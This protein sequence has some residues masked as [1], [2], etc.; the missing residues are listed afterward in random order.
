MLQGTQQ[1]T[2]SFFGVRQELMKWS[3]CDNIAPQCTIVGWSSYSRTPSVL[4]KKRGNLLHLIIEI[5]GTSNSTSTSITLPTGIYNIA[6]NTYSHAGVGAN[7]GTTNTNGC[8]SI[9]TASNNRITFYTAG[10]SIGWTAS[11]S[12]IITLE[13][14]VTVK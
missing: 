8:L 9:V 10:T 12:K 14:Y 3:D 4:V 6:Y 5:S 13:L 1:G 7:N 2:N 11:G